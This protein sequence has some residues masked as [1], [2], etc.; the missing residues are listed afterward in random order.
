MLS[1]IPENLAQKCRVTIID[2]SKVA[3]SDNDKNLSID[4]YRSIFIADNAPHC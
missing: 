3:L 2:Q 4:K 1:M